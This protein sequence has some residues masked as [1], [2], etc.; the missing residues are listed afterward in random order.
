MLRQI[1]LD[2]ETTGMPVS[3]GHRIIEVG[4]VEIINRKLTGNH[5]HEYINPGRDIDTEAQQVHGIS[6]EFLEDKPK[7]SDIATKFIDF[8]NGSELI[9]HNAPFDLGF[10]NNELNL[11]GLPKLELNCTVL[12]TLVLAK[13]LYPGSRNNLDAI[14]SRLGI[15]TARDL[16]G[17][18]LDSEILADA[19][20]LM[21]GGQVDLCLDQENTE[22]NSNVVTEIDSTGLVKLK[23][24]ADELRLHNDFITKYLKT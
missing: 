11:L 21:T 20:L 9:I 13:T 12:D 5:F 19:Y 3:D 22:N 23:A 15:S 24:T 6:A 16:H 14:C 2:T 10:L 18:L 8:V 7:F 4:C 17:A 1:V